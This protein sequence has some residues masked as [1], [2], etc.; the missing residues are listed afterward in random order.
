MKTIIIKTIRLFSII[1]ILSLSYP[2]TSQPPAPP[3]SNSSNNSSNKL[4]GGAA[5]LGGGLFVL[6]TLGVA[7]GGR[8]LYKLNKESE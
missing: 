5:P 1:F 8:K 4:N 7:Y 3:D 2:L 6:L